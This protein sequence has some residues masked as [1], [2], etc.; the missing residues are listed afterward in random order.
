M[1][2]KSF[3]E[4]LPFLFEANVPAFIWGHH[5]IGKSSIVKN[6]VLEM[7]GKFFDI[8]MNTQAD[9]G[10][11]LGLQDFHRDATGRIT[12]TE[13]YKPQ[14]LQ[15]MIEFCE[16]NPTKYGVVFF[17]EINRAARWDLI[18]PVFQMV[19]DGRLHIWKF[20]TNLKFIAAS[21]PSTQD[22]NTLNF[23]DKALLDR[24]NHIALQPTQSEFLQYLRDTK[25]DKHMIDFLTE[26]TQLIEESDLQQFNIDD[27]SKPSR[28]TW[29]DYIGRLIAA[30]TPD[31]VMAGL[32]PGLIGTSA[33]IAYMKSR[34]ESDLKPLTPLEVLNEYHKKEIKE[35]IVQLSDNSSVEKA[36]VKGV[37]LRA[38]LYKVINDN[39]IAHLKN[40]KTPN[41]TKQQITNLIDYSIDAL[42]RD[43][44]VV[45][46]QE[47]YK[48]P[49][50]MESQRKV[51]HR[52]TELCDIVRVTRNL[53]GQARDML[54]KMKKD[55]QKKDKK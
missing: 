2:I 14:W 40:E 49:Q 35:R 25:A 45:F 52:Y 27:V 10:D 9:V 44:M 12:G 31:N 7:G 24:F 43:I 3:K 16:T 51:Q 46:L 13:H 15:D 55:Q 30:K 36:K 53:E 38:D 4:A 5:G 47:V 41:L 39:L 18:G 11:I 1:R 21:N 33:A 42:P 37:V 28:R 50:V 19:L 22:Y 32:L 20:P 29:A 48:L 26:N 34:E 54:E 23:T 6:T 17:D 8:R